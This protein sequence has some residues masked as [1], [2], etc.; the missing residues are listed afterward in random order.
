ML[1][2]HIGVQQER[3]PGGM[4]TA[5]DTVHWKAVPGGRRK[6]TALA[7]RGQGTHSC[8][9]G[10]L[11]AELTQYHWAGLPRSCQLPGW[12]QQSPPAGTPRTVEATSRPRKDL[13]KVTAQC[14]WELQWRAC[15]R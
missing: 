13:R 14:D 8:A 11:P 1:H 7:R 5:M 15:A 3:G 2:S 9:P 12:G 6:G 4:R 10:E